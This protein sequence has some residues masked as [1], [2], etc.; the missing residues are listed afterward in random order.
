MHLELGQTPAHELMYEFRNEKYRYLRILP[1]I[2]YIWP[3]KDL[4]TYQEI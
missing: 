1:H 3:R 2:T 4:C